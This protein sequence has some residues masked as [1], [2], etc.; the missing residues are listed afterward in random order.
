[1]NIDQME[2]GREMDALVAKKVMGL[3]PRFPER[4]NIYRPENSPVKFP[5]YRH[6]E[7]DNIPPYSTSIAAAWEVV[8]KMRGN[9]FHWAIHS[10]ILFMS[11]TKNLPRAAFW[12]YLNGYADRQGIA[13]AEEV[14][15]AVCRAALKAVMR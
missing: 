12:R 15:L 3:D 14:P 7:M 10:R 11:D 2:A 8:E 5:V 4:M 1:M 9:E 13:E 6:V